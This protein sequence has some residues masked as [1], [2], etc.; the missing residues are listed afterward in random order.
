MRDD[1]CSRCVR[2]RPN[3][4]CV[5]NGSG[6]TMIEML[7]TLTLFG[8]VM[9]TLVMGLRAG[10][11]SW[12]TVRLHQEKA[13]ALESAFK[14]LTTDLRSLGVFG[15]DSP[16]IVETATEG[17]AERLALTC[18]GS[19]REQRAGTGHVWREVLYEVREGESGEG[20]FV[21]ATVPYAGASPLAG[22]E[23]EGVILDGLETVRF[24]Y[25]DGS[26]S[27]EETW[28]DSDNSPGAVTVTFEFSSGGSVQ[29]T[30]WLPLG[31]LQ[32]EALQ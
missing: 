23:G 11:R 20:E 2:A 9:G 6:F 15:E 30:V 18:L 32:P 8:L 10:A 3:P 17:G 22:R 19:R 4:D 7:L 16:S 24:D 25:L 21:R 27:E 12:K 13:A 31:S 26:G 5:G 28:E 1:G 29:K 14:V